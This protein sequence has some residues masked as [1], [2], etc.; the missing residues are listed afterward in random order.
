[1]ARRK[2]SDNGGAT[3][4]MTL[5]YWRDG[6]WL[7]G[8]L[9]ELPEVSSQGRTLGELKENI[10]DAYKLVIRDAEKSLPVR[11]Y[12]TTTIGIAR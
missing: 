6:K 11:D 5:Q 9:R 2:G 3:I 4:T 8:R 7:V 12:H 10:V 1:M